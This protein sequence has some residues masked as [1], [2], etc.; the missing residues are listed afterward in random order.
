MHTF[1]TAF[2]SVRLNATPE[3]HRTRWILVSIFFERENNFMKNK[4]LETL[5]LIPFSH[6]TFANVVY[7]NSTVLFRLCGYRK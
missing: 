2:L 3:S 7:E 6:K 1:S 4:T 5:N